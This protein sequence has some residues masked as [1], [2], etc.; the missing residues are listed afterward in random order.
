MLTENRFKATIPPC[1]HK[2]IVKNLA[3]IKPRAE[4]HYYDLIQ[5]RHDS[6][7]RHHFVLPDRQHYLDYSKIEFLDKG[8]YSKGDEDLLELNMNGT[9]Q[10]EFRLYFK[11]LGARDKDKALGD[12]LP[13]NSIQ[14]RHK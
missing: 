3:A 9:E 13:S 8:L 4:K 7:W 11:S 2:Y 1:D 5:A 12:I 14:Q 6:D 10:K